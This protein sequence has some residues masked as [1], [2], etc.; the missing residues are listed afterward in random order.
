MGTVSASPIF[1]NTAHVTGAKFGLDSYGNNG[2]LSFQNGGATLMDTYQ[3]GNGAT[4]SGTLAYLNGNYTE[5]LSGS[6]QLSDMKID[7]SFNSANFGQVHLN[8]QASPG[9]ALGID[10]DTNNLVKGHAVTTL[11]DSGGWKVQARSDIGG[12]SW[13]P[14]DQASIMVTHSGPQ[15]QYFSFAVGKSQDRGIYF[16]GGVNIPFD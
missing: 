7:A 11:Y 8:Y 6:A 3:M 1:N 10:I 12:G 15:P 5:T 9:V 4:I 13:G 2:A 16:E 14:T